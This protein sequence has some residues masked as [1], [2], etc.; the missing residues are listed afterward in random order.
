MTMSEP[1]SPAERLDRSVAAIAKAETP[2]EVFVALF[3]GA[4][5]AGPRGAVFLTRDGELGGWSSF[6]YP[7]DVA[8]RVTETRIELGSGWPGRVANPRHARRAFRSPADDSGVDFG[9]PRAAEAYAASVRIEGRTLAVVLLERDPGDEPWMPVALGAL[10]RIAELRLALSLAERKLAR[11]TA[12]APEPTDEAQ[13]VPAE[14]PRAADPPPAEDASAAPT[15]AAPDAAAPP[16]EPAP[17]E[18]PPAAATPTE[19]PPPP[20]DPD[21]RPTESPSTPEATELDVA[22][23]PSADRSAAARFA[24][25]VATDIRLYNEESVM[26][27]RKHGDLVDRISDH[28]ERG[29]Q[30]FERRFPD[31]GIDGVAILR[32]AYIQVLGG[33]DERLLSRFPTE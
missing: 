32:S 33:G 27:G 4:C 9:Q 2:S 16:T 30:T 1:L 20:A 12:E 21:P 13:A 19:A 6:G 17:A 28:L 5:H 26:L 10:T 3:E 24:R 22:E 23:A 29:R 31:L 11:A 8:T 15:A 25:L 18:D 14:D 7:K